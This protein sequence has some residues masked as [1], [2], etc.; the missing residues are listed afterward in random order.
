MASVWILIKQ[1]SVTALQTRTYSIT[2]KPQSQ[3]LTKHIQHTVHVENY[4]SQ[5]LPATKT[6]LS[7][8]QCHTDNPDR[9]TKDSSV[10]QIN[11][12]TVV[13]HNDQ[14]I[15]SQDAQPSQREGEINSN[16][17][18]NAKRVAECSDDNSELK[19]ADECSTNNGNVESD[20]TSDTNEASCHQNLSTNLIISNSSSESRNLEAEHS[21]DQTQS[22]HED[23][24]QLANSDTIIEKGY[25][26]IR[27]SD[28][29][30]KLEEMELECENVADDFD[31]TADSE[32]SFLKITNVIGNVEMVDNS[33]SEKHREAPVVEMNL[34][35]VNDED[36][37]EPDVNTGGL[38]SL[39]DDGLAERAIQIG[40]FAPVHPLMATETSV[41]AQDCEF[42]S[43]NQLTPVMMCSNIYNR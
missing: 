1:E 27:F 20:L 39:G 14:D 43:N 2:N 17:T 35:D 28:S 40:G 5:Q 19:F 30:D 34:D 42:E 18:N 22:S 41:A 8:G 36:S 4:S 6:V 15:S 12:F 33:F 11:N 38:G 7:S 10:N 24:C 23:N 16:T 37:V 13:S 9:D 3:T 26:V 31:V 21:V 32:D 25:T 29:T